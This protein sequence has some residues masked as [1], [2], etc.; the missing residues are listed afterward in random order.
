MYNQVRKCLQDRKSGL[1]KSKMNNFDL[2]SC[3]LEDPLF[4]DDDIV[5]NL[6]A[7]IF[8][9]TETTHFASQTIIT[10]LV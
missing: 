4:S 9:A 7:F 5:N 6:L 1:T 3:F 10:H 8:A 2:M